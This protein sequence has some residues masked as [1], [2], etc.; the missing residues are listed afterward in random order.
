MAEA[1]RQVGGV[2]RARR[3]R[4]AVVCAVLA[5]AVLAMFCVSLSFGDM[6][7]P[8]GEVIATLTGG[9]DAG[10]GFVILDLR[11]PRALVGVLVGL[12]FGLSGATFQSLLRNPLA[13]PDVIG[14][15]QGASATAVVASVVFGLSGTGL[16]AA[17]LAG[18]LVTGAAI[19]LLGWRKGVAGYRLVLVGVGVGAG[20]SSVVSYVLTSSQVTEAQNALVWLTGSLNGASTGQVWPL[21]GA[22]VVLVPLTLLASRGLGALQLGD[23]TAAGLGT[24][25]ERSRVLLIGCAVALAGVATAAAGP[26]GFV[27]FVSAPVARRLLP[28]GGAALLPSALVGA[29]L[30]L[31][32][33]FAAQHLLWSSQFPV[34]IVTSL[35]GGPYLL[36]LLSR[37]NRV[38]KGG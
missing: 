20:L 22:L 19:Y 34:G 13:S 17:A 7:V 11:L 26:V 32:A 28:G 36:W 8:L 33:D 4:T 25:V 35:I 2:R 27:A 6:V 31:V 24:P 16:S 3:G 29:L 38:G 1:V 14:I 12:A 10:S 37:A 21:L 18:A 15:S 9:G 5:A 30:V 23:D